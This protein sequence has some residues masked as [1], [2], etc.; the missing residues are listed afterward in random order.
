MLGGESM[1]QDVVS[2]GTVISSSLGALLPRGW[3]FK[4][5][6]TLRD[7]D[8]RA[9]VIFSSRPA[10][11]S[12]ADGA[13]LAAA[14]GELLADF[15]GIHQESLENIDFAGDATAMLRR[16]EW[17]PP[18][19]KPVTQLQLYAA[20]NGRAYTATATSLTDNFHEYEALF[21]QIIESLD[22]SR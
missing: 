11:P 12:D 1:S 15:P 22:P 21:G 17:T 14:E 18:D 3:Q 7:P 8:G 20:K 6:L 16:F 4:D 19:G 5:E 9:N 2:D 10:D 13:S